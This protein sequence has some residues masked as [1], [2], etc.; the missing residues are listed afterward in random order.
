MMKMQDWQTIVTML[1]EDMNHIDVPHELTYK[2]QF[3]EL[4]EAYC[5]GRIKHSRRK[6]SH[7][8]SRSPT[9]TRD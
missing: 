5:D 6:R 4:V 3:N 7:W 2:G 9:R 8:A 1:M